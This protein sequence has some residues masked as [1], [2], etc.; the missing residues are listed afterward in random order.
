MLRKSFIRQDIKRAICNKGFLI[1]V[2]LPTIIFCNAIVKNTNF[3]VSVST[4]EIISN[5]M[6][7]SGFTP[8]AAVFPVLAYSAAF[9]EEHNS[10]YLKM[11]LTRTGW[12]KYG[13]TR[14]A[15]VG[16]SGGLIVAIP[17][18]VVCVIG[19]IYGV[20]GLP[21]NGLYA[22][23]RIADYLVKYGDWYVL[24][25]KIILGFLFGVLWALAGMGFAVWSSNRYVALIAP[26]VL[27]EI[28]WILLYKVPVLNPIYLMRGEDINSYPLSGLMELIY[29]GVAVTIV[30]KGLKRKVRYE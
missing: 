5:A 3:G 28:M 13:V 15:A 8:F 17:F 26:F 14:M 11:I 23:T 1:G 29:I 12:K 25:G 6:A 21:E 18:A 16:L 22:G 27:Y 19:Y 7:L 4:Y 30:W 2:I 9:C 10:G 20:P 24:T